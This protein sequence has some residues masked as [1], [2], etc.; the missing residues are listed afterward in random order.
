MMDFMV[1]LFLLSL[2]SVGCV[3]M[4]LLIIMLV[5]FTISLVISGV[6]DLIKE[7]SDK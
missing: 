2:V 3:G 7:W 5:M 1:D 6:K 4:L